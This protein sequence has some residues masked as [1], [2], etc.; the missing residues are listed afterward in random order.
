MT[1]ECTINQ[2][3]IGAAIEDKI[4]CELCALIYK[5]REVFSQ[6]SKDIEELEPVIAWREMKK[7]LHKLEK[8][9]HKCAG[10]GLCFG[11]SHIAWPTRNVKG[12]GDVCQWCTKQ[13][14]EVGLQQFMK[15]R[16]GVEMEGRTK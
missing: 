4:P 14:D 3:E 8:T 13:I 7:Q 5:L 11:G 6:T 2:D 12:L 10:C 15:S 16:E 1:K 9:H